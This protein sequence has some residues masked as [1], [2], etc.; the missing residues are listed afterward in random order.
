MLVAPATP[1]PGQAPDGRPPICAAPPL[2]SGSHRAGGRSHRCLGLA[3]RAP[4]T[5]DAGERGDAVAGT[6]QLR[7][8]GCR[9]QQYVAPRPQATACATRARTKDFCG[10]RIAALGPRVGQP[11]IYTI[12]RMSDS[13]RRNLHAHTIIFRP[14][15]FQSA[16][17]DGFRWV[18]D[19]FSMGCG[20]TSSRPR[21]VGVTLAANPRRLP[22]MHTGPS[23]ARRTAC[24][25]QLPRRELYLGGR[26]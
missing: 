12:Y 15:P 1:L 5:E 16:R 7:R 17:F 26:G 11:R 22:R 23:R 25:R 20:N 9:E 18:F 24:P 2:R 8:G 21:W 10:I 4:P 19:G 14:A 3:A 13:L 6:A